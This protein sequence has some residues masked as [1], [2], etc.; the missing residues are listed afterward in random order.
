MLHT[1]TQ[2]IYNSS[3]TG[4]SSLQLNSSY[5]NYM[6]ATGFHH[7][8]NKFNTLNGSPMLNQSL[9]NVITPLSSLTSTTVNTLN[10]L[11]S[12]T[13]LNSA[14]PPPKHVMFVGAP[15]T[16]T[17]AHQQSNDI[18]LLPAHSTYTSS[19]NY[20]IAQPVYNPDLNVTD[21]YYGTTINTLQAPIKMPRL[22][23]ISNSRLN[24]SSFNN[25][26][27]NNSLNNQL[28]ASIANQATANHQQSNSMYFPV[29][30]LRNLV[31]SYIDNF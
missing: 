15:D 10:S 16:P 23:Y 6:P 17:I 27:L 19:N 31:V 24:N 20:S 13:I 26:S 2:P 1:H 14:L 5:N 29:V 22:N 4:G 3:S 9:N 8:T 30:S 12:T 11:G 21:V 25:H 7:H 28:N 18:Q